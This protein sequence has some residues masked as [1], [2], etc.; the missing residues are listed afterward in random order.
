MGSKYGLTRQAPI[1]LCWVLLGVGYWVLGVGRVVCWMLGNVLGTDMCWGSVLCWVL[2]I[3][4]CVL[5]AVCLVDVVAVCCVLCAGCS[6]LCWGVGH[7][8]VC[9]WVLCVVCCVFSWCCDVTWR[10]VCWVLSV[11]VLDLLGSCV[12]YNMLRV[13]PVGS[14]WGA[15]RARA[16][17]GYHTAARA[18]TP[19]IRI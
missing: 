16:G 8:V 2:G 11:G 1:L 15:G 5:C 7:C 13:M 6:V 18:Y 19:S 12:L 17:G 3:V 14:Q 10:A 9:I 4:L